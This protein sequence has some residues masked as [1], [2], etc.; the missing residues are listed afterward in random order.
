MEREPAERA[1]AAVRASLAAPRQPQ[2]GRLV[3]AARAAGGLDARLGSELLAVARPARLVPGMLAGAD[4]PEGLLAAELR[5]LVAEFLGA[6]AE[7]WHGLQEQLSGYRG[8]LPDLLAARPSPAAGPDE[9]YPPSRNV[10]GVLAF[11]LDRLPDQDVRALLPALPEALLEQLRPLTAVAPAPARAAPPRVAESALMALDLLRRACGDT[12][13]PLPEDPEVL[14]ALLATGAYDL[15][16]WT[17]PAWL[18]DACDAAG[19]PRPERVYGHH[20]AELVT[21]TF[22]EFCAA[23]PA[24]GPGRDAAEYADTALARG[25]VRAADLLAVVPARFTLGRCPAFRDTALVAEAEPPGLPERGPGQGFDELGD[26]MVAHLLDR[27]LDTGRMDGADL[28]I[29]TAPAARVLMYLSGAL[30]RDD[31]PQ[32]TR[33]ALA[34]LAEQVPLI[35]G[36]DPVRWARLGAALTGRDPGWD[37]RGSVADLLEHC[38]GGAA[39]G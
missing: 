12:Q 39:A 31:L 13:P 38:A 1:A 34:T 18:L 19:L 30:V 4:D 35:L 28:L 10:L 2:L 11:L 8:T 6:D 16:N 32:A 5:A 36:T 15:P 14:A 9:W 20:T 33:V 22:R 24:E 21:A 29:R 17:T 25:L 27:A 7:R 37:G 26:G 3:A 23:A